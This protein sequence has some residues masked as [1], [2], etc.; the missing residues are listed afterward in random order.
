LTDERKLMRRA[1]FSGTRPE[2]KKGFAK[3]LARETLA[4][5]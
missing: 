2:Q 1:R 5:G 3:K 4:Y